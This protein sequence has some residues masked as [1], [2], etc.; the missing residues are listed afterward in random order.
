MGLLSWT[1][2]LPLQPVRGVVALARVIQRQAEQ[3]A[4]S[5]QSVRRQ[6]EALDEQDMTEEQRREAMRAITASR[7]TPAKPAEPPER[8]GDEQ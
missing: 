7:I 8:A 6:L 1:V 5:A 4:Y 3:E 2:G